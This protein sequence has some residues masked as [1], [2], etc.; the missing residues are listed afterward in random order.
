MTQ[1]EIDMF[2]TISIVLQPDTDCKN[3]DVWSDKYGDGC[4]VYAESPHWCT[5][6]EYGPA[7]RKNCPQACGTCPDPCAGLNDKIG[8]DKC[9]AMAS[10]YACGEGIM[11]S[12]VGACDRFC[13]QQVKGP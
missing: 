12:A 7:G 6:S 1:A 4:D 3:N 5:D 8:S 13:C 2:P 10:D 9:V 11:S